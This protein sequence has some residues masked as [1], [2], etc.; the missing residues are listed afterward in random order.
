MDALGSGFTFVLYATA[1]IMCSLVRVLSVFCCISY[2]CFIWTIAIALAVFVTL[3][4]LGLAFR[5]QIGQGFED[6]LAS[7][8]KRERS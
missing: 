6:L 7:V 2:L 5:D 3:I 8:R 4:A 1:K